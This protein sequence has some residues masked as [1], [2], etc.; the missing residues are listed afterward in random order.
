MVHAKQV[1]SYK[2][3]AVDTASPAKLVL[4]LYDG[5][6][7]FLRA[8]ED[9]FAEDDFR[10]RQETVHNNLIKTQNI[11]QELQRCLNLREGGEFAQNMFRIYDFMNTRLMDA[12]MK[13]DPEN[14]R[15]VARL[16]RELRDAWDQ[17]MRE[18]YAPVTQ[19]AGFSLSA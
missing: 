12:N 17:M 7:R 18:Q 16:V 14:I 19:G 13:K 2:A 5:A 11:V 8:A 9:G 10:I 15:I 4:M 6:L 1:A 3:V